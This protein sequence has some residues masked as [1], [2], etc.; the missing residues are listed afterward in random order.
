[1]DVQHDNSPRTTATSASEGRLKVDVS[2]KR[3]KKRKI[4]NNKLKKYGMARF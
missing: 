2:N 4:L 1:M 3:K